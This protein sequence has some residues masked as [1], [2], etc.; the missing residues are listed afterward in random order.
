MYELVFVVLITVVAGGGGVVAPPVTVVAVVVV[1]VVARG[2]PVD[3]EA[4]REVVIG[5]VSDVALGAA[6]VEPVPD[7]GDGRH[8]HLLQLDYLLLPRVRRRPVCPE[9]LTSAAAA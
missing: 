4:R 8:P 6:G 5:A 3:P 9:V 2:S 1:T 7:A